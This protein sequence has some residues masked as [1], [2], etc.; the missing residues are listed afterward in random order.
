MGRYSEQKLVSN[1]V[2]GLIYKIKVKDCPIGVRKQGVGSFSY[3]YQYVIAN[4]RLE[5]ANASLRQ[6]VATS[7]FNRS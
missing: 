5:L 4:R 7:L 3:L 6:T 1:S 2:G